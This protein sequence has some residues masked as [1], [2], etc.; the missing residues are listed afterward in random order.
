MAKICDNC[1]YRRPL[2]SGEQTLCC[3]YSLD[4]GK[5]RE[6]PAENCNKKTTEEEIMKRL[7]A[8]DKREIVRL[9]I[10]EKMS[11][12]EIAERFGIARQTVNNIVCEWKDCVEVEVADELDR[13]AI[14]DAA[15]DDYVCY[16]VTGDTDIEA[17]IA[18]RNVKEPDTVAAVS[19][20]EQEDLVDVPVDIVPQEVEK[21][22]PVIPEGVWEACRVRIEYLRDLIAEEQAVIDKWAAEK[23]EIED[24]LGEDKEDVDNG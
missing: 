20:S 7:T 1:V 18:D 13:K 21:V 2:S 23:K 6:C 4:T 17:Y 8:E 14:D 19:D 10:S 22:K 24:F 5:L 12:K 15:D 9:R 3:H 16:E 11:P